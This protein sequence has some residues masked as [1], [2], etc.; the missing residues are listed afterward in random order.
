VSCSKSRL[1][2]IAFSVVVCQL[3]GLAQVQNGPTSG[4]SV[5]IHG[6]VRYAAGGAPA[7]NVLVRLESYDGGG[8]LAEAFT[9]RLGKFEFRGL[10]PAQYAV[11]IHQTGYLD[12]QQ[13]V[14]LQ[15]ASSGYVLLQLSK[16]DATVEV[17]NTVGIDANVPAAAQKEFDKAVADIA[18]GSKEKM[19]DGAR[20][21][22]KAIALYP[23]FVQARLKL[24]TAYM[25]L[26]EWEQAEHML[27]A[28]LELDPQ[29]SNAFFA[30]GE[31]YLE[32]N[33]LV[34]AESVLDE[35]L[36][37]EDRSYFGHLNLARVFWMK[38]RKTAN[39]ESA[40]TLLE[41]A[42]G[43]VNRALQLNVDLPGAHLLKGNLLLR[44]GRAAEAIREFDEYLR[45]EPKGQTADQTRE[46]IDKIRKAT[47]GQ[48][49]PK[50]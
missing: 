48:V 32:Q 30:L 38:S 34:E 49:T 43:E 42:Y 26:Q 11:K 19:A 3:I 36:K 4:V 10:S 44:A 13:R 15:T 14:D 25:D 39:I 16:D 47:A 50:L 35:G 23:R 41:K 9:D 33:K 1:L 22:Q 6:Q 18:Q 17:A 31:V 21:L 28:T 20:H 40:K 7:Q 27:R 37:I 5:E 2:P 8:P 45:L 46:V 12:A 29:V 24:G